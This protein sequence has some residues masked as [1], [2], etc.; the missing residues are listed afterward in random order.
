MDEY[1]AASAHYSSPLFGVTM[2]CDRFTQIR[3]TIHCNI[4]QLNHVH[5][6]IRKIQ[7]LLDALRNNCETVSQPGM[8]ES[9]R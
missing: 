2:S 7:P 4:P 9:N 6:K 5:T 8:C 1:W 3:S